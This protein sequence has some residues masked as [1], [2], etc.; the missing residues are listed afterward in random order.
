MAKTIKF[1]HKGVNYTLEFTR[2]TVQ[3]MEKSGFV[4]DNALTFPATHIPQLFKGA[5]LAHHRYVKQNVIDEIFDAMGNK[6]ELFGVLIDM[7]S[8]PIN[9]LMGEPEDEGNAISWEQSN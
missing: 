5:F 2:K 8:E 9:T 4:V 1:E 7:Y 3:Q 6:Q